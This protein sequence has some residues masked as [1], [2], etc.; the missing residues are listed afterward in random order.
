MR[1]RPVYGNEWNLKLTIGDDDENALDD[2]VKLDKQA[3]AR[4]VKLEDSTQVE[5]DAQ[6]DVELE[7]DG[8]DDLGHDLGDE[9]DLDRVAEVD[10]N[11]NFDDRLD[12]SLDEDR[13]AVEVARNVPEEASLDCTVL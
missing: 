3:V 10:D 4:R 2:D 12:A 13:D 1:E 9:L 6:Q 7:C 5:D 11:A 8:N